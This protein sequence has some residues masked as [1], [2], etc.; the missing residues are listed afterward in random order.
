[1]LKSWRNLFKSHILASGETYF[2][3]HRVRSLVHTDGGWSALVEGSEGYEYQ[4]EIYLNSDEIDSMYCDCPYAAEDRACKHMAAVLS[5]IEAGDGDAASAVQQPM[6]PEAL[7]ARVPESHLRP[8]LSELISDDPKLYRNLMFK[9][10]NLSTDVTS[11]VLGLDFDEICSEY[12][13]R[14]GYIDYHEAES[15]AEE[16]VNFIQLQTNYLLEKGNPLEALEESIRV[17]QKFLSCDADDSDG[18]YGLVCSAVENTYQLVL[19]F[20]DEDE[21]NRIF[22]SLEKL[23]DDPGTHWLVKQFLKDIIFSDAGAFDFGDTEFHRKKLALLDGQIATLEGDQHDESNSKC[24]LEWLLM[25][26]FELMGE[27]LLSESERDAFLDKYIRFSDIRKLRVDRLLKTGDTDDAVRLLQEGKLADRARSG[28]VNDYSQKLIEVYRRT[29]CRDELRS[30]LE[31][32]VFELHGDMD[33]LLSLKQACTPDQWLTYRE[34]YLSGSGLCR[35]DLMAEEGLWEQLLDAVISS[36]SLH[37]LDSYE[38]Y[39]KE[40]YPDKLLQSY[41]TLLDKAAEWANDRKGYQ[42]LIPYLEKLCNYPKGVATAEQLASNWRLRYKRRRA[43]MEE[44][45]NAGF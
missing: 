14:H 41:S 2:W 44:L 9:Y 3:E 43:M 32:M 15:F 20:C 1:M 13:G 33:A 4:V 6:S 27:L 19:E 31:S 26:R 10:G 37:V 25:R 30:E 23:L 36:G 45:Q 17:L 22:D 24:E 18:I 11:N 12:L 7:A 39:L 42:A 40:L 34:R 28:L 21:L 16:T 38:R 5:A 8:L 35:L 29:G